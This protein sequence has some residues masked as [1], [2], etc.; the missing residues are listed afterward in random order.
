M[1][2]ALPNTHRSENTIRRIVR[3]PNRTQREPQL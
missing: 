2:T 1:A 3:A